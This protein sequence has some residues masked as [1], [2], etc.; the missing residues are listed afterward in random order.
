MT[1]V[2]VAGASP[3][4]YI[5]D[6]HAAGIKVLHKSATIRHALK[7]QAAGCDLV[8]VVG[9]E[10]SIAGGQQGD[11]VGSWVMLAKATAELKIPVIAAGA[12]GTG[13]QLAA[14][15]AMGAHGITMATRFLATT[16]APGPYLLLWMAKNTAAYTVAH[17]V[18]GWCRRP[19]IRRSKKRSQV[20]K[21]T[22]GSS[23]ALP[24]PAPPPLQ[25]KRV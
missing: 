22:N 25:L 17:C 2:E 3:K 8:E 18:M 4:K 10:G 12:S 15:L 19:S 20:T 7:A 21:P 1:L 23:Y 9:Y 13:R 5:K 16:E 24:P 6:W 14:A 11:E